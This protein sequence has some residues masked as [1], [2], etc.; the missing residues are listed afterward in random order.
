MQQAVDLMLKRGIIH[1]GGARKPFRAGNDPS[2]TLGTR[3]YF[4]RLLLQA[5]H[6]Y[7][8]DVQW[9][10]Q[11]APHL[12]NYGTADA[13]GVLDA[14]G[15]ARA[16]V[17]GASMGGMVAQHLAARH[18]QRVRSLT[19]MMTTSGARQ[20]PQ[21][22]WK[23]RMALLSRPQDPHSHER[24]V[25]HFMHI[26]GVIGSPGYPT[27]NEVLR[28]RLSAS[29]RRA[30]RPAATARQLAAILA[31]GDR[32]ALLGG[33]RVPT[34]VIHGLA[35]PLVPVE[36]GRELARLIPSATLDLIAGMGHDLPQPLW[37][38]FADDIAR[39]AGR[40]RGADASDTTVS[41]T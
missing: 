38:R 34:M 25:D 10:A 22:G 29:V 24:I 4:I 35:D 5:T 14:L 8:Q 7:E 36:A 26:Y 11:W 13:L 23:V 21:P 16:H 28:E 18:P 20:L 6:S 32:T 27:E 33:I 41:P 2:L 12:A 3:G 1:T 39:I 15:I 31:D 40:D 17:C 19:L 30:Y 9:F 37:P